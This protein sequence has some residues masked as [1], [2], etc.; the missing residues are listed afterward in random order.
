[1]VSER[2]VER[3]RAIVTPERPSTLKLRLAQGTAAWESEDFEAARV[4]FERLLEEQ[5]DFPDLHNK[6]GLCHAMLGEL[7]AAL[8]AFARAVEL[9]P[10]YV[11]AMVNRGLVLNDL[12]RHEEA[13][14]AFEEA[15][16]LDDRDETIPSAAGNRIAN[17]HGDVG[18]LYLRAGLPERAI[19][20]Y[21]RALEIRP[22]YVDIRTKLAEA[23]VELGKTEA[24]R[25][26]LARV[27]ES[28]PGFASA[29]ILLGVVLNQL[30]DREAAIGEWRRAHRDD[31]TDLRP[32]A[33][34]ATV[35]I[36]L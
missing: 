28:N 2:A 27:V 7:E 32:R 36:L 8:D 15:A 17:L 9:A 19:R 13:G 6:L 22:L 5:P 10:T 26:E 18:D 33:Y 1:M 16:K 14:Q 34:L 4:V 12:G 29:R 21:R 3:S 31:P 24:A 30:G 11:E 25:A 23:L 20:E 35:G